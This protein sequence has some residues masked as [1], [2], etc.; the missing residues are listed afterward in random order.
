MRLRSDRLTWR[1]I[2]GEIVALDLTNSTYF[3]ANRTASTMLRCLAEDV[4]R[5]DLVEALMTEYEVDRERAGQDVDE[6][7]GVLDHHDLL[8]T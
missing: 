1:E 2:D 7:L 6:F 4:E 3:S 8:G 5:D